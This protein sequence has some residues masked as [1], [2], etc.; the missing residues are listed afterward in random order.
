MYFNS[1]KPI[2]VIYQHEKQFNPLFQ[3][4]K[5]NGFQLEVI[6]PSNQYYVPSKKEMQYA[7]I[8]NDLSAPPY[9]KSNLVFLIEYLRHTEAL[10]PSALIINGSR[11]TEVV[12]YQT[13]QLNV[14][15]SLN[16]PFP[17]TI[18]ASNTEQFLKSIHQL[19]F[20]LVVSLND[21]PSEKFRFESEAELIDA[22]INDQLIFRKGTL[23][24]QEFIPSKGNYTVKAEVLNGRF[25]YAIK[26]FHAGVTSDAWSIE[27]RLEAFT[28]PLH[29][30]TAIERIAQAS[31]LDLGSITYTI[32]RRSNNILFLNIQPHSSSY[33]QSVDGL[34]PNIHERIVNYTCHR[35]RK[36]REI[37]LAI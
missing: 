34:I 13:R 36:I 16:M 19:K 29:I 1:E 11:A 9:Q 4:L 25:L 22:I 7:V 2:G 33:S 31:L 21:D 6:N 5:N 10:H 23:I 28:P 14:L 32:D 37:T 12:S 18:V 15:A 20:P 24:I 30:I 26:I 27:T 35:L 17:A 3:E 8:L